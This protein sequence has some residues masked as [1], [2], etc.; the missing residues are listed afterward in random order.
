M[1]FPYVIINIIL[2]RLKLCHKLCDAFTH[3][4][5]KRSVWFSFILKGQLLVYC[6]MKFSFLFALRIIGIELISMAAS[7]RAQISRFTN[8]II[9]CNIIDCIVCS[10]KDRR[11]TA[12]RGLGS[13]SPHMREINVVDKHV[14]HHHSPSS[15]LCSKISVW[16]YK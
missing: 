15:T 14:I 3:R 4:K 2:L 11:T 8:A 1:I 12:A 7:I 9:A 5:W 6:L 13:Y 16:S 10:L